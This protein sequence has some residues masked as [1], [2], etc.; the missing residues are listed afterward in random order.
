MRALYNDGETMYRDK[1]GLIVQANGDGGD[2]AQRMGMVGFVPEST[3]IAQ[4]VLHMQATWQ[5]QVAPGIFV[6]HPFQPGFC[7]DPTQYSRDQQDSVVLYL[8]HAGVNNLVL[9]IFKAQLKRFGRYQNADIPN[10]TTVGVYARALKA[11][12]MYP[13]LW[14]TDI[15]YLFSPIFQWVSARNNP[16]DVDDN[17]AIMRLLQATYSMPT[18]FSELG[19]RL[20]ALIRPKNYGCAGVTDV[21]YSE[22][23]NYNETNAIMGALVW[24]HRKES[25]GNPE[26]AEIYRPII[27]KYFS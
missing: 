10:L 26:I 22:S 19:R 12:W 25:G 16:A 4:Q 20:Y 18:P 27:E 3:T 21:L 11:S 17:N 1:Y 8:G 2:T 7:S 23:Y 24:Y 14:L 15:T 6:R 5:L 9:N 13:I